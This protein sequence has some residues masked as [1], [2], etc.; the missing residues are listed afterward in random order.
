MGEGDGDRA[1]ES[2]DH[3]PDHSIIAILAVEV[4]EAV[5]GRAALDSLD[6]LLYK[7]ATTHNDTSYQHLPIPVRNAAAEHPSRSSSDANTRRAGRVDERRCVCM[8]NTQLIPRGHGL[9]FLHDVT[10]V[11]CW[12]CCRWPLGPPACANEAR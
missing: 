10:S 12:R 9:P 11:G 6:L 2:I 8:R 7:M 3:M 4:M 1:K 5:Q